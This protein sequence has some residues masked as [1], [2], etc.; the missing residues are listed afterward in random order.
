MKVYMLEFD[1]TNDPMFADEDEDYPYV[2]FVFNCPT[3]MKHMCINNEHKQFKTIYANVAEA[4]Q[5]EL[6]KKHKDAV[7][8]VKEIDE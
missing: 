3:G 2:G 5:L 4:Y 8:T 1:V 6:S 7:Y